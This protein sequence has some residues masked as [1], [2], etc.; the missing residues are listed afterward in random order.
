VN[1]KCV[2]DISRLATSNFQ[3]L[4]LDLKNKVAFYILGGRKGEMGG[5]GAKLILDLT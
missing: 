4:G 1:W 2:D 5:P 3:K